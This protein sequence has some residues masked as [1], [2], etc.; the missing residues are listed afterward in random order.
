MH[1]TVWR[2]YNMRSSFL[3]QNSGKYF[4]EKPTVISDAVSMAATNTTTKAVSIPLGA[5]VTKVQLLATVACANCDI[6]VGD[7]DNDDRYMDNL[8]T[9]TQYNIIQAPSVA[10]GDIGVNGNAEVTGRYYAAAD[11]IDIIEGTTGSANTA[12]GSVKLLVWYYL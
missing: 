8:T 3:E 9:I 1:S 6:T 12:A 10:S 5:Y 11:T 7:G 4:Q 2:D